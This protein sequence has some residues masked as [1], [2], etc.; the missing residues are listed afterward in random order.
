MNK[1]EEK[2]LRSNL[3]NGK[4]DVACDLATQRTTHARVT[5]VQSCRIFPN[6]GERNINECKMRYEYNEF[7]SKN[8]LAIKKYENLCLPTSKFLI[9]AYFSSTVFVKLIPTLIN[10]F[11]EIKGLKINLVFGKILLEFDISVST[12]P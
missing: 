10:N 8:F 1:N 3:W 9:F 6:K 4:T 7:L 5:K 12:I 11:D 2:Q